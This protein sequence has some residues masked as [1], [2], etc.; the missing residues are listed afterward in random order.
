MVSQLHTEFSLN[1][2][3]KL[4]L[5]VAEFELLVGSFLILSFLFLL[6]CAYVALWFYTIDFKEKLFLPITKRYRKKYQVQVS[7]DYTM[8][9]IFINLP[10]LINYRVKVTKWISLWYLLIFNFENYLIQ[11]VG[12]FKLT[13]QMGKV[14]NSRGPRSRL[15]FMRGLG[16]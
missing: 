7:H 16:K 2:G 3:Y 9:N 11:N 8:F 6:F 5:T 13:N 1:S 10:I 12:F 15:T 4:L 14:L